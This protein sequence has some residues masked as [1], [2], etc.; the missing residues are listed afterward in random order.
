MTPW[1]LPFVVFVVACFLVL[2]AEI[3]LWL[4]RF[5]RRRHVE[6]HPSRRSYLRI[7]ER[8]EEPI[9]WRREGWFR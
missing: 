2:V 3:V 1:A 7:V 9:D 8:P 6:R 5:P 4:W